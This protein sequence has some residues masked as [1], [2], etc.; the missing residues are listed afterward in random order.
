MVFLKDLNCMSEAA[1]LHWPCA[2]S[3]EAAQQRCVRVLT[4]AIFRCT[5]RFAL[6]VSRNSLFQ[7]LLH[8]CNANFGSALGQTHLDD[9]ARLQLGGGTDDLAFGIGQNRIT[10]F[11]R[12]LR[13]E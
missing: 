1:C 11:Q 13:I 12:T 10:A 6:T 7:H 3:F 4:Y 9:P 5:L 8:A 2:H